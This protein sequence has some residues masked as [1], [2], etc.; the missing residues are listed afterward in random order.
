MILLLIFLFAVTSL[1]FIPFPVAANAES[2][3]SSSFDFAFEIPDGWMIA[4][5]MS[6]NPT[7]GNLS[8]TDSCARISLSWNRDPGIDLQNILNQ[9]KGSYDGGGVRILSSEMG[10]RSSEGIKIETLHLV[11]EF[12]GYRAEKRFAIWNSSESDR[13]FLAS[14]SECSRFDNKNFDNS[15]SNVYSSGTNANGAKANADDA[16]KNVNDESN[17]Q[18]TNGKN[19]YSKNGNTVLFNGF[20]ESFSDLG[21]GEAVRPGRSTPDSAWGI[22][23]GDL[24]SSYHY[25][26]GKTLPVRIIRISVLHSLTPQNG[27]YVLD[28]QEAI[29]AEPQTMA[30]ARAGA[31]LEVLQQAGYE[32]KIVQHEGEVAVAVRDPTGAWQKVSVNPTTPD[33]M[34]GVL[35]NSTKEEM[36]YS[37]LA[38]LAAANGIKENIDIHN[39]I[40]KDS[41]PSRYVELKAPQKPSQ[42]WLDNLTDVLDSYDYDKY[43]EESIFDCSNTAQISWSLLQQKGYDARLMMSYAGHP[44]DPHM[45]LVVKYPYEDDR[46]V[47][48]ETANTDSNKKLV[49]LGRIVEDGNHFKGIIYNSSIQFSRMHPEEGMWIN[50]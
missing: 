19:S 9:I 4:A 44:L 6:G 41:E 24:L 26:D 38:Q 42:S 48:V 34:I 27:N 17:S 39:V 29:L 23:L 13:L 22:V 47:A 8:L 50:P 10:Q 7:A 45:W 37:N 25:P 2:D 3:I 5:S 40:Q 49:H 36:V 21:K 11:Y 15:D 30:N 12:N 28:S 46:Y 16:A 31:V 20:I 43:Y 1:A 14:L 32:A 18:N 33:G 35:T